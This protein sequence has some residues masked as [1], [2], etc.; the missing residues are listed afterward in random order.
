VIA[1]FEYAI[2]D[3]APDGARPQI[4]RRGRRG[5]QIDQDGT[6]LPGHLPWL[7]AVGPAVKAVDGSFDNDQRMSSS[8]WK[9]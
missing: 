7:V 2:T 5:D 3:A 4:L 9:S 6:T 1:S 8:T